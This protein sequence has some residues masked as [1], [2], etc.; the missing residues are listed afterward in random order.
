MTDLRLNSNDEQPSSRLADLLAALRTQLP[1]NRIRTGNDIP[2]RHHS[3][4]N[5][6]DPQCPAALLQPRNTDEVSLMMRLCHAHGQSVVPQGGLTGLVSG[7]EPR[8]QD[9]ALSLEHLNSIEGID[10]AGYM[11]VQSGVTLE[12]AQNAAEQEGYLFALD[13]GARGSC[14]IGGNIATNAGGNRVVRYGM[15]R[16]LVIGLEVVLADGTVLNM[17]DKVVK[18]NT[19]YDL[20]QMFI[21]SEGTLGIITRAVLKLH[22]QPRSY[23]CALLGLPGTRNAIET[24]KLAHAALGGT[25]SAYE[26]MFPDF[27]D[28]IPGI[29]NLRQPLAPEHAIYVLLDAQGSDAGL[30]ARRF[31]SFLEEL[32]EQGLIADAAVASSMQDAQAFWALRDA[33]SELP[34]HIPKRST[35]DVSFPLDV[36]EAAV[37]E[38]REQVNQRW[39]DAL[40]LC[41]GHLGDNNLHIV[42]DVP[43]TQGRHAED[44]E[45]IVYGSVGRHNGAISAEHGLGSKKRQH[46]GVTRSAAEI[47]TMHTLKQAL[48]PQGILNPGKVL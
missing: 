38:I 27:Y 43:G 15:A 8:R 16:Q 35:F 32:F 34:L 37:Q 36:M 12:A 17:L 29:A 2:P 1:E 23:Q 45:S 19:G 9:I 30:D 25:L 47:A 18:N 46:I 3:D 28:Y 40:M 7:A 26:V 13:I 39:P 33:V 11:T 48:D 41:F 24:L 42:V 22:P 20:K 4:W 14:T 21:G 10:G 6:A 44:I 31:Q 5:R